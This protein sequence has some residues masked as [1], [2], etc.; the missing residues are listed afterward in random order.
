MMNFIKLI[1]QTEV[2][3]Q[4]YDIIRNHKKDDGSLL[5]DAFIRI[6]KRRQEPGYYEVSIL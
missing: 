4:L 1:F 3:Q 6:P 5:C 2:V